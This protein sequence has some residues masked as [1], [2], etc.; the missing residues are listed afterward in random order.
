M[1]MMNCC[2]PCFKKHEKVNNGDLNNVPAAHQPGDDMLLFTPQHTGHTA[3]EIVT[4]E[5][6]ESTLAKSGIE[7]KQYTFRELATATKHF[8]NECLLSESGFGRIY[9]GTLQ[10]NGQVVFVKRLD[11]NSTQGNKEFLVEVLMLSLLRHT[12]LLKLVGYCADGDQKLLVYDYMPMGSVEEHLLDLKA[13]MQPLDWV[14]R[15]KIACG[16]A[17]GI[18]YLHEKA[19]PPIIYRDLKCSNI[20]LDDE[21]NPKLSDYGLAKLGGNNKSHVTI[22]GSYGYCAPEYEKHG[23]LTLKSDVYSFGVILLELISGRRAM[24]T[25]KQADEQNLVS[26]VNL[27]ILTLLCFYLSELIRWDRHTLLFVMIMTIVHIYGF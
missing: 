16:T 17:Q 3:P 1:N 26:W 6:K 22:M 8:R 9:R 18:E 20:M 21:F 23:E 24:D 27:I 5:E 2:F 11:K 13:E 7:A 10:P 15:M 12:N 4:V 25:S 14:Q 19:N